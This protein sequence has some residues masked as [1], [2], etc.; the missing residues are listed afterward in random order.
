M[1]VQ[2]NKLTEQSVFYFHYTKKTGLKIDLQKNMYTR[3]C[4][5]KR[6]PSKYS[7]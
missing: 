3:I 1:F 5:G 6:K 4:A 2:V 7:N